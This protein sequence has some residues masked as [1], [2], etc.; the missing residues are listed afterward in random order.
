MSSSMSCMFMRS[1]SSSLTV[2][3]LR[4]VSKIDLLK[5]KIDSTFSPGKL[6]RSPV[7]TTSSITPSSAWAVSACAAVIG[8]MAAIAAAIDTPYA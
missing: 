6:F 3:T 1:M 5:P 4:G 8:A 7:T 2:E